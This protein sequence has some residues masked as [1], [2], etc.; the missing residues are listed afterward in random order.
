MGS[1]AQPAP[2][3]PRAWDPAA[4]AA[5]LDQRADWWRSWPNAARDHDTACVSCHT[6]LPYAL[7]RPALRHLLGEPGPTEAEKALVAGVRTRVTHWNEVAPYYPDQTVGLPKTSES[8]GTEAILNALVLTDSDRDAGTL[9]VDARTALA[10]L[11]DLQFTRGE[12][13]GGWA[14]LHFGLAPWESDGAEYFGAALAAVAAGSAPP[15]YAAHDGPQDRLELLRAYLLDAW[16]TRPAFDRVMLAWATAELPGLLP[17]E[18]LTS[19]VTDLRRLQNTDGGWTLSALR[20]WPRGDGSPQAEASDGYGTGVVAY[21]LLRTGVSPQDPAMVRALDWLV[22]HQRPDTGGWWTA[23]L[24][25]D[26]DPDS[27]RGRFM[28][29]AATAFAV[30]ALAEAERTR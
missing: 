29:D 18:D 17:A 25:R 21:V 30:L 19:I 22:T 23:S 27:D 5:Y 15:D 14:W 13:T 11:W 2:P 10:N 1:A 8:R 4:A 7:A 9:S 6:S 24:N 12:G 20:T 26:R 16:S 28:S 3:A